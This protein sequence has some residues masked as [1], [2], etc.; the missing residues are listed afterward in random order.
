LNPL[1]ARPGIKVLAL[2]QRAGLQE[3]EIAW[4]I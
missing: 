3:V 4:V 2:M 1:A